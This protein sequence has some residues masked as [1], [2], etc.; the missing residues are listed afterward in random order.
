MKNFPSI[1]LV[2]QRAVECNPLLV[3]PFV[4]RG[5][6]PLRYL[7]Q[8]VDGLLVTN[9]VLDLT[10]QAFLPRKSVANINGNNRLNI[11][12]ASLVQ[13][14]LV[15]MWLKNR[16]NWTEKEARKWESMALER[17]VTGMAY[18]MRLVLQGIYE[19]KD[20]GV[21]QDTVRQLVP[22]GPG[23]AGKNR[24]TAQADGPSGPDDRESFGGD[25]DSLGSRADNRLHGGT[26][27][28]VLSREAQG[29]WVPDGGVHD[30]HA[31]LCCR[32]THPTVLLT[33]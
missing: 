26:Q 8:V 12:D 15:W 20:V 1:Q 4:N 18:E 3:E 14:L 10:A 23:D 33:H 9:H 16:G 11:G 27:Q 32:E 13:R 24:R 21:R 29:P 22:V 25:P 6:Q 17:C 19:W 31:L 2:D 5:S 30:N 7:W 28:P